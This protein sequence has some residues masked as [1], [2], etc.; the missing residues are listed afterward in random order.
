[1]LQWALLTLEI[2]AQKFIDQNPAATAVRSP[3]VRSE[4]PGLVPAA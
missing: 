3:K 1:M 2:W 4:R